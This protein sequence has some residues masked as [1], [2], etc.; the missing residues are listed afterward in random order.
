MQTSKAIILILCAVVIACAA[1]ARNL[2]SSGLRSSSPAA[3]STT[4]LPTN[5]SETTDISNKAFVFRGAAGGAKGSTGGGSHPVGDASSPKG[6]SNDG[7]ADQGASPPSAPGNDRPKA[8]GG[9]NDANNAKDGDK[10]SESRSPDQKPDNKQDNN[11][12]PS[13][14]GDSGDATQPKGSSDSKSPPKTPEND[15]PPPYSE[16]DKPPPYSEGDSPSNP[17]GNSPP[18]DKQ[19][20]HADGPNNRE[21]TGRSRNSRIFPVGG[22]HHRNS[23]QSDSSHPSSS[24]SKTSLS[25]RTASSNGGLTGQTCHA[26]NN[27]AS[28]PSS[29]AKAHVADNA[30]LA[31]TSIV[32]SD[33]TGEAFVTQPA[34]WNFLVVT[35]SACMLMNLV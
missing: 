22:V 30:N 35:I 18:R 11:S 33:Y 23:T 5:D 27:M 7:P 29:P 12:D 31:A 32:C 9:G 6:P 19:G 26:V 34:A 13:K 20:T 14:D 15:S 28:Q 24:N 16:G 10:S 2:V 21:N 25:Q 4:L 17:K 3:E 8:E 1:P